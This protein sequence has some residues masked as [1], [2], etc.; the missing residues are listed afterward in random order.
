MT[1]AYVK[2]DELDSTG[3][4]I[5]DTEQRAASPRRRP[6]IAFRFFVAPLLRVNPLPPS[7]SVA[8]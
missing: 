7:P 8:S 6:R 3:R 4:F 1:D 5:E 2:E